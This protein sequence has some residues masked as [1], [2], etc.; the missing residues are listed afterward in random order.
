IFE[1]LNNLQ[2]MEQEYNNILKR[3]EVT[4]R[5]I[6]L[7]ELKY[8]EGKIDK[9]ELLKLKMRMPSQLIEKIEK[10]VQYKNESSKLRRIY[11][12]P[13]SISSTK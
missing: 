13:E 7:A 8:K 9:I 4:E 12:L 5:N 11:Y 1:K 3:I 2:K 6:K 10:I